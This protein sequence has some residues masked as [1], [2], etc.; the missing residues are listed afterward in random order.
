MPLVTLNAYRRI[1]ENRPYKFNEDEVAYGEATGEEVCKTC[2][3]FFERVTDKFH[4]CEIF[5]PTDDA[6]VDPA[7]V[8]DFHTTNGEAFPLLTPTDKTSA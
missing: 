7:Y 6:S 4:T 5:R 1:I 8:C 2:A 3:H